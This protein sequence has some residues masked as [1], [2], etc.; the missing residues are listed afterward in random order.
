M[1]PALG[2]VGTVSFVMILVVL[3]TSGFALGWILSILAADVAMGAYIV[4]MFKVRDYRIAHVPGAR[5][6]YEAL[7]TRDKPRRTRAPA[8]TIASPQ[9]LRILSAL[10]TAAPLITGLLLGV[11]LKD[12]AVGVAA[13]LITAAAGLFAWAWW[14]WRP[15]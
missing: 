6:A 15:Q 13:G 10:G 1:K 5:L 11:V 12:L 7:L 9:S 2:A 3:G 4:V 8:L 14:L